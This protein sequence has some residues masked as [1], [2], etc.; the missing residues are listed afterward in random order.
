MIV[1]G[2]KKLT[3]IVKSLYS[4]IVNLSFSINSSSS[5]IFSIFNFSPFDGSASV[6]H[7]VPKS[8]S[9]S[10]T[11]LADTE[12]FKSVS[13]TFSRTT[14]HCIIVFSSKRSERSGTSVAVQ[15]HKSGAA[16][17]PPI[18][19]QI[20]ILIRSLRH[21]FDGLL[22]MWPWNLKFSWIFRNLKNIPKVIVYLRA[23]SKMTV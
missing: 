7:N 3:K 8:I 13:G 15:I 1:T 23:W 16:Q 4:L 12:T 19:R 21:W 5:S 14:Q 17:R 6:S 9:G 11:S 10:S 22:S 20:K 2:R 18:K